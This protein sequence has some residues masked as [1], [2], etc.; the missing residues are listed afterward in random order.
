[1]RK[2][3]FLGLVLMVI[4]TGCS[5]KEF[6]PYIYQDVEIIELNDTTDPTTFIRDV[7]KAGLKIE[8]KETD[9]NTAVAGVYSITYKISLGRKSTEKT[10]TIKVRDYDAPEI[11]VDSE[12]KIPYGGTFAL[13]NF[14]S[15]LDSIDGDVSDSLHFTGGV[16]LYAEGSYPI[17][18]LAE[19]QFGNEASKEVTI[20]VAKD[21]S[22]KSELF[23]K[24]TDVSYTD[25]QAPTLEINEDGTFSIYLNSCSVVNLI[26]GK[27]KQ[28]YNYLYLVADD[29]GFSYTE[30]ENVVNFVIEIDGTLRFNSKLSLCAPNFGD[31]FKKDK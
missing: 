15:A 3:L 19:D 28:Y 17:V 13:K 29:Y 30:E 2:V 7:E 4:L 31:Y 1:M 18:V 25:G 12:I 5:S 20:V 8:V 6:E 10:F 26:E 11:T 14:A 22:Y 24:Y 21:N 23:G 27:Y 16:N 9:L